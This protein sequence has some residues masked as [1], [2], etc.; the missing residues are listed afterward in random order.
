M[1]CLAEPDLWL[2]A[3]NQDGIDY[4]S[5]I[6][7]YVDDIMVIHHDVRPILDRI[8]KF[9]KIKESSVGDLDIYLGAKLKKV[10]MDDDVWC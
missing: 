6:L 4:Y 5:Y 7:C 9:M 2:K 3:H 8:D 1:P 10:Q